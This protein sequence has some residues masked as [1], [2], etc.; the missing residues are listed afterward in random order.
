MMFLRKALSRERSDAATSAADAAD[1]PV[2]FLR[3][4]LSALE[5]S[6]IENLRVAFDIVVAEGFWASRVDRDGVTFSSFADF[7]VHPAPQGLEVRSTA[8]LLIVRGMLM[9]SGRLREWTQLLH[10][11]SRG[12]GRPKTFADG[13]SFRPFHS[14]PTGSN[15][16]DRILLHLEDNDRGLFERVCNREISVRSAAILKG[17]L[18][19]TRTVRYDAARMM[20]PDKFLAGLSIT[21]TLSLARQLLLRMPP[22]TRR[23]FVA[24]FTKTAEWSAAAKEHPPPLRPP[25]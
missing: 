11:V 16:V 25:E 7:A 9:K 21:A 23:E 20:L 19:D 5:Q 6:P 2:A 15:A 1:D 22:S 8:A 10:R 14:P 3:R 18:L 24:D 13:E 12:P 4:S 17:W